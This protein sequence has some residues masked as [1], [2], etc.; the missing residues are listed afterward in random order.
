MSDLAAILFGGAFTIFAAYGI[1]SFLLRGFRLPNCIALATGSAILSHLVFVILLLGWADW[2]VFAGIGIVALIPAFVWGRKPGKGWPTWPPAVAVLVAYGLYYLVHALAPEIRADGF[3]YH[4]GLP[5]EWL[6]LGGFSDRIGFFEMVPQGVEMLF[7]F[8]YAFG[9]HS[10]AK[11]VHFTFLVST[12][13]LMGAIARRLDLP[14]WMAAAAAVFYVCSPVVGTAG[15]AAYTDAAL[16]FFILASFYLLL[17]WDMERDNRLL[18]ATGLTAGFCYSIKFT[19]IIIVP[20]AAG[21]VLYRKQWKAA[22]LLSSA[23]ALMILPW[24]GRNAILTGNPV[25]PLFNDIFRNPY[26]HVWSEQ[27]L[28]ESLRSYGGVTWATLPLEVTVRGHLLQ[29]LIGPVFLLAP[30][31]LIGLRTRAGRILLAAAA[32]MAVPWAF[33]LGARFVMPALAFVALAMAASLPRWAVAALALTHGVLSLPPVMAKCA[34][35][36]AW[37]LQG[38]PIRAA[39]RIE[40]ESEYLSRVLWEYRLAHMVN[41]HVSAGEK[42]LDLVALPQAY[43]DAIA[44]SPWHSA[45]GDRMGYALQVSANVESGVYTEYRGKWP[46]RELSAIRVQQTGS[47]SDQWGVNDVQL[48]NGV[49]SVSP[50]AD[51]RLIAWPNIWEAPLAFDSNRVTRWGTWEALTPEMYLGVEFS[52]PKSL[53]GARVVVLTH[54]QRGQIEFYGRTANGDWELLDAETEATPFPPLNLR[55]SATRMLSRNSIDYLL[56][57]ISGDG[58][59]PLGKLIAEMPASWGLELVDSVENVH[60]YRVRRS[61]TSSSASAS[62]IWRP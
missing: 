58:Y 2:R 24:M 17:E 60:L 48:Y 1:G 41:E 51:W 44:T 9:E 30:A 13:P 38:L 52:Q 42:I 4:L 12:V 10:A 50:A 35:P 3:T 37:R 59:G 32:L 16:V 21:W 33:N 28:G 49:R 57:P 34:A 62:A 45:A 61:A 14:G 11:L 53:T 23:A 47:G 8:A 26:F 27:Y 7:T 22:A 18:L 25:A 6:R 19:G 46:E 55:L 20:L 29:G 39:L 36:G 40:P 43:M 54:E 56:A 31:A 5:R 15:T